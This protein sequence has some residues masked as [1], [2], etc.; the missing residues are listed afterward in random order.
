MATS[1]EDLVRFATARIGPN[2]SLE[3]IEKAVGISKT[4][5]DTAKASREHQ[6]AGA[7]TSL[8]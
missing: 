4:V 1:L 5:A 8:E 6:N 7:Q 2:S 3:E